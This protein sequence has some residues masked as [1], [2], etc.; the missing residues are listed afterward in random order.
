MD[1]SYQIKERTK[2]KMTCW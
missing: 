2:P 1:I